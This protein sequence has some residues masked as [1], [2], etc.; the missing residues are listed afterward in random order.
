LRNR[1]TYD[2]ASAPPTADRPECAFVDDNAG[3]SGGTRSR[4]SL[5]ATI[6][7]P[8]ADLNLGMKYFLNGALVSDIARR[9]FGHVPAVN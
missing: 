8:Q 9:R 5:G 3:R 2:S 1:F 6:A 7:E 4:S